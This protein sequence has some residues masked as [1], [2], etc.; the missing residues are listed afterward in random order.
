MEESEIFCSLKLQSASIVRVGYVAVL[1]HAS[2]VSEGFLSLMNHPSGH[3]GL[4][5][6]LGDGK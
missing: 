5:F 4:C 2:L 6:L 1:S 3:L